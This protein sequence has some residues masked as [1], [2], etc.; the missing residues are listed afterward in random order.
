MIDRTRYTWTYAPPPAELIEKWSR[1][2]PTC[3]ELESFFLNEL[4]ESAEHE[5]FL[6]VVDVFLDVIRRQGMEERI[7]SLGMLSVRLVHAAEFARGV[8]DE[9]L[10]SHFISAIREFSALYQS[11]ATWDGY[12]G[13][14]NRQVCIGF[15]ALQAVLMDDLPMA[16]LI[17]F[18]YYELTCSNIA[19]DN[20]SEIRCPDCKSYAVPYDYHRV[21]HNMSNAK[22]HPNHPER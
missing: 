15:L 5:Y 16:R 19:C 14:E 20:S 18:N 12:N 7:K 9:E 17:L 10:R 6:C 1:T 13:Y 21:V 3:S 22:G 4:G 8:L 2:L 11:T